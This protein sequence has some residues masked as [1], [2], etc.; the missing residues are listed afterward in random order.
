MWRAI[1]AGVSVIAAA[2][3]GLIT[4]L[5]TAHPSWGLWVALG[6]VVVV[7]AVS[8]AAVTLRERRS[9]PRV[10]ASGPGSVGVGGSA[11]NEIRV[12]VRG[13]AAPMKGPDTGDGVVAS[14]QGAVGVGGDAEGR[15]STD[16]TDSE[17]QA[18]P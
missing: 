11:R 9:V 2:A 3:S 14:G 15:I 18:E 12:K 4:S 10:S 5:V 7:G 13:K 1:A 8:Q 6:V 17:G 16:V